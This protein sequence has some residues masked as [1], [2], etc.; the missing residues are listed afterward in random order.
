MPAKI[1]KRF[2][3]W[4]L[5]A[6]L[7]EFNISSLKYQY[8]WKRC[9]LLYISVLYLSVLFLLLLLLYYRVGELHYVL[10]QWSILNWW[11]CVLVME[12]MWTC[13]MLRLVRGNYLVLLVTELMILQYLGLNSFPVTLSIYGWEISKLQY[14]ECRLRFLLDLVPLWRCGL[15]YPQLIT[16]AASG[17]HVLTIT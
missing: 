5:F 15:G 11:S 9:E 12:P 2:R 14:L 7:F 3:H 8:P 1:I 6:L 10:P 17:R 16:S 4:I 13:K